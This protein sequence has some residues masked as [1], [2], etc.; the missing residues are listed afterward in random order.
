MAAQRQITVWESEYNAVQLQ[1][2]NYNFNIAKA[3][4]TGGADAKA[5]LIW[6]SK[7]IAPVTTITWNTIYALNWTVSLPKASVSV[8]VGGNWQKCAKGQIYELA[9]SGYWKASSL[10]LTP[11]FM[12]A[13]INYLYPGA[14]HL[15]DQSAW[16]QVGTHSSQMINNVSTK[17]GG[18]DLSGPAPS[19]MSIHIGLRF[20]GKVDLGSILK[21]RLQQQQKRLG[22]AGE[23]RQCQSNPAIEVVILAVAGRT[24]I[25]AAF[26]TDGAPGITITIK[27]GAPAN[28]ALNALAA[29]GYT[30]FDEHA[31]VNACMV[32]LN[33]QG[34]F[35]PQPGQ[36]ARERENKMHKVVDHL[37]FDFIRFWF[38][39]A[40][41]WFSIVSEAAHILL[42]L[43][44][45]RIVDV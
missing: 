14:D 27:P 42:V 13:Y 29:I 8:I 38:D 22:L 25:T 7:A 26:N 18:V 3:V 2:S 45:L 30:I 28:A 39:S 10:D 34:L 41:S 11:G 16:Y 15:P 44:I 40:V 23:C 24:T 37:V 36:S 43:G 1:K 17:I 12:G 5:N 4:S 33:S 9:P 32:S 19:A 35:P 6:Q 31:Q 20:S 21:P